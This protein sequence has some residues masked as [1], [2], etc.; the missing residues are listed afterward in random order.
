MEH[1]GTFCHKNANAKI[2]T[3]IRIKFRLKIPQTAKGAKIEIL[4]QRSLP[5]C[6]ENIVKTFVSFLVF[7]FT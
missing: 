3:K 4:V 5:N 6:L 7:H 2:T 1:Y